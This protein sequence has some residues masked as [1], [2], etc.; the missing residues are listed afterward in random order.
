MMLWTTP[1]RGKGVCRDRPL[2]EVAERSS[3]HFTA[4]Q[5]CLQFAEAELKN[6]IDAF[7]KVPVCKKEH[8]IV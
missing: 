1:L 6:S 8:W 5:N 7:T 2:K 4:H 3:S